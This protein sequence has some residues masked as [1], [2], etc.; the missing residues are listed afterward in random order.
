MPYDAFGNKV[1][2]DPLAGLGSGGPGLGGVP[3]GEPPRRWPVILAAIVALAV[4]GGAVAGAAILLAGGGED[5]DVPAAA[6]AETAVGAVPGTSR[7][8]ER[9]PEEPAA[10]SPATPEPEEPAAVVPAEAPRGLQRGS[11][12][13]RANFTVALRRLR[14][15]A[16]GRPRNVRVEAERVD[17]QVVLRDGRLRS[18]QARWDGEIRVLSTTP[19]PIGG[20]DGFAWSAI[21]R[22]A[23]QRIVRS[24]T[25]RARKPASAFNYAVLLDAAGLRWS[26]FLKTGEGFIATSSGRVER[27]IS[28]G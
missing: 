4:L 21:D 26:A 22:G 15:E 17:V 16:K 11:L 20:L 24:A 10:A 9:E 5:D 23:P 6:T 12:L 3:G 25:G 18:A 13:R 19:T 8:P 14:A 2:D 1:D 28:G 7:D 27:Q